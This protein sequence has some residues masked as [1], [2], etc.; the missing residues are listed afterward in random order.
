[1]AV[2]IE[3]QGGCWAM[4]MG[5]AVA[6]CCRPTGFSEPSVYEFLTTL[7]F[8][9]N[10]AADCGL[11][12]TRSGQEYLRGDDT[13][14][15]RVE[16]EGIVQQ[17]DILNRYRHLRAIGIR[18][19][20][21][22]LDC[23]APPAIL[24]R[25]KHLGLAYGQTLVADSEEEM[26]LVFD[27]AVHTAKPGRSRAID[28]YARAA[29][30]SSGSDEAQ[31]LAAICRARFSVWRIERRHEVA[32]VMV[33]DMLRGGETWLVDEA[34]TVSAPPGLT[35]ASRLYWPAE[36]AMTCGIVVPVDAELMEDA[37]M[38][39]ISWMRHA[40]PEQFADDPRFA[41]AVY[42]TALNSGIMD[43]VVFQEPSGVS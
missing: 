35:F 21:A 25:A 41:T 36:F 1:M 7:T 9:F 29:A 30:V 23:L 12:A 34:L 37:L 40:D 8:N 32:G 28:R 33:K 6:G 31:T 14:A 2:L 4:E 3:P 24:E 13:Q 27:L 39:S 10:S 38:E 16:M 15:S 19:H 5:P 20:S 43:G 26:T 17:Q 22:A 11:S 18:L 42:R